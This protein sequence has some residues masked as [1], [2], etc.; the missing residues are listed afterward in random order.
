MT[1]VPDIGMM[2]RV[3][4]KGPGRP[5]FNPWSSHTNV[6][7]KKNQ[8]KRVAPYP[9]PWCSSYRKKSLLVTFDYGRQLHFYFIYFEQRVNLKMISDGKKKD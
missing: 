7:K 3:F 2:V 8:R 9:T 1:Y 4:A 5:G 6:S